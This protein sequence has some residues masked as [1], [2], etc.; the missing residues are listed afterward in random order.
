MIRGSLITAAIAVV[1]INTA[2]I[3]GAEP[4]PG[5]TDVPQMQYNAVLGATCNNTDRY[6]FGRA[7]N[8]QALA[9]IAFDDNGTWVLSSP[10]R[11]VQTIGD[12]C[13]PGHDAAAQSPDGRGLICVYQQGWQLGE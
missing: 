1:A 2:G 11:G 5:E 4:P 12:P 10:L 13:P 6:I 3:A 8:G 7:P 9:C